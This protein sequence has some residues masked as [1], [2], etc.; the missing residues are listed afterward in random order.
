[1]WPKKCGLH[2]I[3]SSVLFKSIGGRLGNK[4]S[5]ELVS[6]EC[7]TKNNLSGKLV[8]L[9]SVLWMTKLQARN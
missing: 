1:M 6:Y 3:C 8:S 2:A 5:Y 9:I 4:S 7:W